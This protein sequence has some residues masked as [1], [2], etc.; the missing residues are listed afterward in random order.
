M[1][2]TRFGFR[3]EDITML[4]DD[5]NDPAAWPTNAN[6]RMHMQRLVAGAQ[7]GDSLIFHYSGVCVCGCHIVAPHNCDDVLV[8]GHSMLSAVQ[9]DILP[10]P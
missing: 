1:L 6:M 5:Q 4:T 10:V 7:A 3:E 8:S 9:W 2:K